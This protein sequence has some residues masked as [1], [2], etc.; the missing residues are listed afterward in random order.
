MWT[1]R[2]PQATTR[3]V[4]TEAAADGLSALV[5][6]AALTIGYL[7]QFRQDQDRREERGHENGGH[8]SG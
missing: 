8:R 5:M 7:I 2:S 3:S 1:T 6:F 4:T